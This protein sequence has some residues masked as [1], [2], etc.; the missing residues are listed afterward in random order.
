MPMV[1]ALPSLNDPQIAIIEATRHRLN[2]R[3]WTHAHLVY[4]VPSQ[5][6]TATAARA[7]RVHEHEMVP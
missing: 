5:A 3:T 1:C 2:E 7:I 6:L 4:A